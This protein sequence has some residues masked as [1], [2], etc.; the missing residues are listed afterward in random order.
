MK[1]IR[2]INNNV[3]ICLD[4]NGNE[5]VAFGKGIGFEKGPHEI[6]LSQVER[7]Y[8]DINTQY[9]S[10]ISDIPVEIFQ[11]SDKIIR[12]AQAKTMNTFHSN[13]VFTLADHIDFSIKRHEKNMN[14]KLPIIND[15]EQLFES[16]LDVGKYGLKLILED[17]HVHLPKEEAAYIAL[18]IINAKEKSNKSNDLSNEK[19]IDDITKIIE[20]YFNI[21]IDEESFNYSRFVS[22]MNYLLK[23]TKDK[24]MLKTTNYNIYEILINSYQDT[25][26]CAKKICKYL[27]KSLQV[28]LND[29]ETMYLILH[30]NRLCTREDCYL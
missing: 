5:I 27:K 29:E 19:I 6:S 14:I 11:I 9:I 2:S 20:K 17:L 12:Y 7:T 18:H 30:I 25:Y 1:V 21:N 10:M 16:E 3:A 28:E 13:I 23:R 4:C 24:R 26:E 8:Y 22:H 15:I